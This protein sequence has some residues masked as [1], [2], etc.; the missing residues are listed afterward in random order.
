LFTGGYSGFTDDPR[1]LDKI[2]TTFNGSTNITAVDDLVGRIEPIAGGVNLIQSTSASRVAYAGFPFGGITQLLEY[3][4]AV[5]N[6]A[7]TKSNCTPTDGQ[8]SWDGTATASLLTATA[9]AP[10][11]AIQSSP[12]YSAVIRFE[13]IAKAG[14]AGWLRIFGVNATN[15]AAWFDLTNGVTGTVQANITASIES[16]GNGWWKCSGYCTGTGNAGVRLASANGATNAVNGSTVTIA[17]SIISIGAAQVTFQNRLGPS[18]I[19]QTG[20]STVNAFFGD[21]VDDFL[22]VDAASW[23]TATQGMFADTGVN[24]TMGAMYCGHDDAG[25]LYSQ[26]GAVDANKM[27]EVSLSGGAPSSRI[28]GTANASATVFNNGVPHLH[29]TV[30][31]NGVVTTYIDGVAS[32][33]TV[34]AAVAE[35]EKLAWMARTP[36]APAGHLMG[37]CDPFLIDRALS[38]AEAAQLWQYTKNYWGAV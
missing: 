15:N 26:C 8:T 36:S 37:R 4:R 18:N 14:T 12:S 6:A 28:R 21:G 29:L 22:F 17:D 13:T 30:I 27:L 31:T 33:P 34:G 1:R 35:T 23:G 32:T 24:A 38:A 10:A 19:T 11:G 5:S 20:L 25:V 7:W 16:M 9:A 3:P 2:F